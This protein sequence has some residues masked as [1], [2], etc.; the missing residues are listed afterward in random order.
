MWHGTWPPPTNIGCAPSDWGLGQSLGRYMP[1]D[2]S[3]SR[4]M[5]PKV[6]TRRPT[7]AG[8]WEALVGDM[9]GP[10]NERPGRGDEIQGALTDRACE[11]VGR[12]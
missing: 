9:G 8:G 2:G 11:E 7:G 4:S 3:N 12:N 1:Q 6:C 10:W 5:G